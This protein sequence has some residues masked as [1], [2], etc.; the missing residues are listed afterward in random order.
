MRADSTLARIPSVLNAQSTAHQ[1]RHDN[2]LDQ[3]IQQSKIPTM[4]PN[5]FRLFIILFRY[6]I[7]YSITHFLLISTQDMIAMI[8]SVDIMTSP[9]ISFIFCSV[10]IVLPSPLS[11][12][13]LSFAYHTLPSHNRF[14]I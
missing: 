2:T 7:I 5:L 12:M 11:C 8:N 9:I 1:I 4:Q 13:V 14:S 10:K 6:G 3:L